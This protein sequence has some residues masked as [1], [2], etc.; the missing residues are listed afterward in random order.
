MSASKILRI[1][2]MVVILATVIPFG[3]VDPFWFNLAA[4]LNGLVFAAT[5]AIPIRNL[6]L[7][8]IYRT[9]LFVTVSISAYLFFQS[10]QLPQNI[11]S[12]PIW[13]T[14]HD[15][16]NIR[17]GAIS[18]DPAGTIATIPV[19]VHPF[20]IFM[21]ALVLL[22]SDETALSFWRQLAVTGAAIAA[23]GL[24]QYFLFPSSLLLGEKRH[25]L[26]SVTGTFVNRNSAA[27]L[28]GI[29]TLLIASILI[30][31]VQHLYLQR[32]HSH[33][34]PQVG[35][36][37][38]KTTLT[39][40]GGI[41][42]VTI[43]AL[44][45]TGSRGGLISTFVPLMLIAVWFAL[46]LASSTTPARARIGFAGAS[47]AVLVLAFAIFGARSVFRLVRSGIDDDRWC[48]YRSTISAIADNP[49]F[50]TGFGTFQHVF[51]VYRTPECGIGGV[52]DRAHNSFLEGYL[53]MGVAFAVFA[54]FVL[55]YLSHLFL[56]GYRTRWRFQ[57]IP[58]TGMA[59]LLLI[60]LHSLVDF[61]LQIPGVA[62]YVAAALGA[63]VSVSVA[64]RHRAKHFS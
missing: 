49:W 39:L 25:Y 3:A 21:A 31:L 38:S 35:I 29:A 53:G 54:V 6:E 45:L 26:D 62:A 44:F 41:F 1:G 58:L 55:F 24:I 18:V 52:W 60:V 14:V 19:V 12:N 64:R 9:A 50:G 20:L 48:V 30:R 16:L 5:L 47:A 23:L 40:Y 27:T 36:R 10:I 33:V 15:L 63:A 22:Q 59:I 61:S 13:E 2:L 43:L 4:L 51:P 17:T 32:E 7:L 57:I 56:I 42:L 46:S 34:A 8:T 28:F 11:F 37:D